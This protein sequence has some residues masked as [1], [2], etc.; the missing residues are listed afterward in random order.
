MN[1][2]RVDFYLLQNSQTDAK[3]QLACRL[4]NKI[5]RMGKTVLVQT[6]DAEQARRLDDLMWTFDQGSF[7]P[8]RQAAEQSVSL[9]EPVVIGH[10][11]APCESGQNV[12]ISLMDEAPQHYAE[13]E[14]IADIV[15]ADDDDKARARERFRFYRSQGCELETHEISV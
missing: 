2:P 6:T 15:A 5:Y 8:H 12:L 9:A 4:A 10:G 1:T 11:G 14:R 3:L 7:L 13:Y